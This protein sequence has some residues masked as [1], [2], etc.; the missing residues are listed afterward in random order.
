[1]QILLFN[2]NVIGL[3]L[4]Q[5]VTL[6][7]TYTEPGIRGN[8]AAGKSW[9]ASH[10]RW[11]RFASSS[12]RGSGRGWSSGGSSGGGFSGGGGSFG[13]GGASGRW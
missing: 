10:P 11:A 3:Q 6:A 2:G 4:P 8:T 13:G 9:L 5:Q 7:V 12:D 1:V